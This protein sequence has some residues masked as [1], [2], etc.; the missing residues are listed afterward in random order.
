[1]KK[2]GTTKAAS[3]NSNKKKTATVATDT[4][5]P[6]TPG[7]GDKRQL[8]LDFSRHAVQAKKVT[9][10]NA[11]KTCVDDPLPWS[12]SSLSALE[13]EVIR[14]NLVACVRSRAGNNVDS[15]EKQVVENK[16]G[17]SLCSARKNL[18][19]ELTGELHDVEDLKSDISNNGGSKDHEASDG[20][21]TQSIGTPT[22]KPAGTDSE[23]NEDD[24]STN[25]KKEDPFD[26]N[27][28]LPIKSEPEGDD[29]NGNLD[30]LLPPRFRW[31]TVYVAAF[32]LALDT[33][34]PEEAFLFTDEEHAL[35]ETYRALPGTKK[36]VIVPI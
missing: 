22:L 23:E 25:I 34:L 9:V 24:L 20:A 2:R 30:A 4:T 33:V 7:T 5:T 21:V 16:S 14:V 15:A 3:N 27:D 10:E 29:G 11:T 17:E 31:K 12:P 6:S 35:F 19:G 28:I 13:P 32:E 26:S 18:D 8:P 36:R 1:M